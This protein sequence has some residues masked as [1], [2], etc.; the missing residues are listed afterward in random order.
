MCLKNIF[1]AFIS[2]LTIAGCKKNNGNNTTPPPAVNSKFLQVKNRDI[3]NEAGNTVQLKGVAFGNE[4]WSNELPYTHHNET[5]FERVQSMHMNCIRFYMNYKTFEDDNTPYNYKQ[6]G[7][8]WLDKN[9]A[10][11]KKYGI[12]LI[13]NMHA[14]QGGYQSQGN[15]DALWT[16]PENQNRLTALW[17][18]IAKKYKDEPVII[19]YGLVNEPVPSNAIAQWNQ[20]AQRITDAIRT[21]DKNHLIFLEKAIYVKTNVVEDENLFFPVSTDKNTV[22]EFHMYDPWQYTHQLFNWGY[23]A[24]GGKYPD[25]SIISYTNSSWH[26]ATFNNPL[27]PA[28][29]TDWRYFEGE[30]YTVKDANIKL[31]VPAL[32]GKSCNG[33]V[34]FDDII[35]KEYNPAGVFTGNILS[36]NLNSADNWGYW[37][38]NN[39]G[40]SGLSNQQGQSDNSSLYI[41]AATGDC[42]LSNYSKIFIPK[43]GYAYQVSGWMK[44]ENISAAAGCMLRIDFL[45]T[46]DAIYGRNKSFLQSTVQKFINWSVR[47]NVPLYMGE[48]GAGVHC[49]NNDKGGLQWVSD[50]ID[51]CKQ[52]NLHFTYHA[53][54]EDSFGLYYGYG[55]LPDA[56]K[57]NTALINLLTQ[58]LK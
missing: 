19:G 33:T 15:G 9:I 39:S 26:T 30:K 40:Q 8:D 13:L 28:G 2:A 44:G 54:H 53:Y 47:K 20:L 5:D 12:Y 25:E 58:K 23:N 49:F 6:S 7:W 43:Q 36:I 16:V 31:A 46:A 34:Y 27:L 52:N 1:I 57:A 10:W 51:I 48:F 42:N 11:A 45:S 56:T 41:S 35:I 3:V 50:M 38:Q 24:D 4:I 55:S 32:V 21:N 22:Y 18:A 17:A 14:P 29:N 37:S